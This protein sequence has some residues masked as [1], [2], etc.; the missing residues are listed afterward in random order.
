MEQRR[1]SRRAVPTSEVTTMV[2][3]NRPARV[4]D[5]SPDGALLELATALSPGSESS[6]SVPLPD[7]A[8]QLKIR[9]TRCRLTGQSRAGPDRHLIYRAGVKFLD[10]DSQLATKICFAFPPA[11]VKPV[12]RGP[13]KVKVDVDALEHAPTEGE[14]GPH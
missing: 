13:I 4:V 6:L 7:G 14:H 10:V 5:I 12:R 1:R 2:A 11:M 3:G 8:V 9:V